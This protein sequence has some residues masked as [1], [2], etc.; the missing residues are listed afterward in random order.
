MDSQTISVQGERAEVE[1]SVA[2]QDPLLTQHEI[3]QRANAIIRERMRRR[4]AKMR[5]RPAQILVQPL[6]F[7]EN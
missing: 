3:E 1:R 2:I 4:L 7:S 6:E 5:C